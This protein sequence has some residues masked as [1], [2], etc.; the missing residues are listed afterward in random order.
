MWGSN[1]FVKQPG[2]SSHE[3]PTQKGVMPQPPAYVRMLPLAKR[4]KRLPRRSLREA[5]WRNLKRLFG[6]KP[7]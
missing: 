6:E 1:Y 5:A 3:K 2:V 7:T 4:Q